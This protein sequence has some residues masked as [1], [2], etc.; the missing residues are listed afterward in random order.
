[1]RPIRVSP[2]YFGG[3]P[4]FDASIV[5]EWVVNTGRRE[6][7]KRIAHLICEL[8]LR[9]KRAGL[10]DESGFPWRLTQTNVADV[11]GLSV[12]HVNRKLQSLG[13]KGLI[14]THDKTLRILN[15]SG[16]VE[17]AE[18]DAVYLHLEPGMN[19]KT[20]PFNGRAWC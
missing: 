2:A 11:A 1:M 5:G 19:D 8:A 17:E 16:L 7:G 18:F 15:W 10:G 3:R 20:A 13:E 6:A 4:W 12:V 14:G 9:Y